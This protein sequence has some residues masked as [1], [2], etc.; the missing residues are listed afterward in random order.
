[1]IKFFV[2]GTPRPAGS[3]RGFAHKTTGK[4][5]M[6]D[7]SGKKGKDWRGDIK[8]AALLAIPEDYKIMTGPV[9][10][11]VTFFMQRPKAHYRT[12]KNAELL[13]DSAPHFH[14]NTPDATKLWRSAEDALTGVLWIDD[15]QV[16]TVMMSKKWACR[17]TGKSGMTIS[18]TGA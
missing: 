3:K 11:S 6:M 14:T 4:V 1:M 10:V 15:K 17:Y 7:S 18:V 2:Q 9:F 5:I 16:V 13:K 12:G 8:H